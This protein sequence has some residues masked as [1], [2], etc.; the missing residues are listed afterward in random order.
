[1]LSFCLAVVE[2]LDLAEKVPHSTSSHGVSLSHPRWRTDP[3]HP[4][5]DKLCAL[6]GNPEDRK[7]D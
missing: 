6:H 4:P 5:G 7:V 1:M 2:N 3:R